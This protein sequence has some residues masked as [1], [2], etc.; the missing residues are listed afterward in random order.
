[1]IVG[2]LVGTADDGD[3][4][5]RILPDLLVADRRLE[6]MLVLVDPFGETEGG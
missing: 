1:M 6:Q 4:H 2:A 5:V 3:H